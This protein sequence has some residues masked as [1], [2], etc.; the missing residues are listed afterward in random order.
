MAASSGIFMTTGFAVHLAQTSCVATTPGKLCICGQSLTTI[1][2]I[3][4]QRNLT[5]VD[6]LFWIDM[7][8]RPTNVR[9]ADNMVY[10]LGPNEVD[11]HFG[12]ERTIPMSRA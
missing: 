5:A 1:W 7:E 12:A 10:I 4:S 8:I 11:V 6:L 2:F 3:A 9:P